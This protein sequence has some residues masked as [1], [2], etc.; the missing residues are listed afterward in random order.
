MSNSYECISASPCSPCLPPSS[1][2]DTSHVAWWPSPWA[3]AQMWRSLS[4]AR[5]LPAP[6]AARCSRPGAGCPPSALSRGLEVKLGSNYIQP[7]SLTVTFAGCLLQILPCINRWDC[8]SWDS[9]LRG[10][11]IILNYSLCCFKSTK[12][13]GMNLFVVTS[14]NTRYWNAFWAVWDISHASKSHL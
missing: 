13:W 8:S 6:P 14:S 7:L 5:A 11:L 4:Q 9:S 3:R 12:S 1:W 2:A 10:I